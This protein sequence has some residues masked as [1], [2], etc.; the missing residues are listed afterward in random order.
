[1]K[2]YYSTMFMIYVK[3]LEGRFVLNDMHLFYSFVSLNVISTIAKNV[4]N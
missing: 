2:K 4:N 3:K 1:M